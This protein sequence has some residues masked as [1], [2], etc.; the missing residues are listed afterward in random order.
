[1]EMR[2]DEIKFDK[3]INLNDALCI[4]SPTLLA[5][6]SAVSSKLDYTPTAA[7]VG[8]IITASQHLYK[9]P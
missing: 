7:M 9:L 2:R 1:M 8:S 6:L 4:C 5:L 3:K